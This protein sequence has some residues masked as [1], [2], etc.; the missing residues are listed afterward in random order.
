MSSIKTQIEVRYSAILN[1]RDIYKPIVSPFL[2]LAK[3]QI[4]NADTLQEYIILDF[5]DEGFSLDIRWDRIIFMCEGEKENLYSANGPMLHF[6]LILEKLFNDTSFGAI[7][8]YI[9]AE[10]ILLQ[11]DQ[12]DDQITRNFKNKYLDSSVL[13]ETDY[14][15]N[16]IGIAIDY[17]EKGNTI[18]LEFGPYKSET[19]I[20]AYKLR[21]PFSKE[22]SNL[23]TKKGILVQIIH[24]EVNSKI[25][26]NILRKMQIKNS[27]LLKNIK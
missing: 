16:D 23:L 8:N 17:K 15:M 7:T 9:L 21:T 27:K 24:N 4:F 10:W 25:D 6:F 19:D 3:F 18:R 20:Q 11:I 26:I 12:D 5:K 2:K 13:P 22:F 14:G 1:F